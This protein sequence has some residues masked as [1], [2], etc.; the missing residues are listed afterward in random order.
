VTPRTLAS[1]AGNTLVLANVRVISDAEKLSL[2]KYADSG[3]T[4]VITGEDATG[5][6]NGQ[7]ITRFLK[8]PG[9]EYFR[10]LQKDFASASPDEQG[11]F[12]NSLKPTQKIHVTAAASIATSMAKVDGRPHI[13]F[14]NFTGLRG[15]ENPLPTPQNGVR[16][17]IEGNSKGRGFF[18]PFLGQV[19]P[20]DGV[21][22]GGEV[23]FSLPPIEKGAVFWWEP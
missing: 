2:K 19:S 15:G 14:A 1:F 20:L 4:L 3:R 18:L 6:A 8:C 10:K 13:Y 7:N 22:D 17:T 9:A 12:L 23:T 21:V 11:E 5:L 16:I